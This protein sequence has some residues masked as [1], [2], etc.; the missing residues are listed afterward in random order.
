MRDN[1]FILRKCFCCD[2]FY[3]TRRDEKNHN[4]LSR[5]QLD[6]RQLTDDK[7]LK[8]TF[9]DENLKSFCTN[10]LK[11]GSFHNL[12]NSREVVSDFLTVFE[13][14]FIPNAGLRQSRSTCSLAIVNRQPAQRGGFTGIT[15]GRIWQTKVYD[16]IYS[17]DF[18]KSNMVND[19]LKRVIMNGMSGSSWRVKRFD[20]SSITV[21]SDDLRGI[22]K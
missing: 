20:R 22:G 13:N 12:Y 11:H 2:H 8:K 14:N 6:G 5:Y 17:N 3:I 15:D 16:G 9:F 4:F 1:A 18:I 7:P 19:I 21:N 10:F